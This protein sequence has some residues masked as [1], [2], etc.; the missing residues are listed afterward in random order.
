MK[1]PYYQKHVHHNFEL[2]NCLKLSFINIRSFV[3][4]SSDVNLSLNQTLLTF[5]LYVRQTW[6]TQLILKR[7]YYVTHKHVSAVYVKEGLSLV[8]DLFLKNY[9]ESSYLCFRLALLH[10]FTLFSSIDQLLR[11]Y[12][13]FLMLFHLT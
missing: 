7:K 3:R 12:A 10:C 9:D 11:L 8:W 13:R 1:W 4:I 6:M 5:L 2:H